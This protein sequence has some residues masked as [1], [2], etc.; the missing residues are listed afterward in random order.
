MSIINL[1]SA[2]QASDFSA[3]LSVSQAVGSSVF[4]GSEQAIDRLNDRWT[5]TLS[6]GPLAHDQ[7][8]EI[9]AYIGAMRGVVNTTLIHHLVRPAPRG[10][11]RGAMTLAANAA[12]GAG[13][14]QISGVSPAAGT[15]LAGDLIGVSGLLLQV[16]TAATAVA[17][18]V[19]VQIVN[20][21]RKALIAGAAVTW[22][23]PSIECRLLSSP[24]VS[25]ASA[26]ANG[27]SFEY[28]EKIV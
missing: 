10:T 19:T 3:R 26:I 5:F 9:E 25:Y 8:A 17:G 18:V 12:Q 2:F 7:A 14:V 13:A 23:K 1:P 28:A 24:S 15:F 21:L 22:D 6:T 4:G 27:V 16:S 11:A 20:R